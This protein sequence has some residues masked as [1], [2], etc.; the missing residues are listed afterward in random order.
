MIF[1]QFCT[2][3]GDISYLLAD[4]VTR[5]AALLDPHV[6][7]RTD[8][9]AVIRRLDLRLVYLIETHLHESHL[10]AAPALRADTDAQ[11]VAHNCV[12]LVCVDR[13][14]VD[15]ESIFMGEE[16]INAMETPGHSA[17]SMSYLWRDRVF[18]GHTLLAG[19]TGPCHRDDADADRL[20]DSVRDRLFV[21]PKET[22]V[23]PGRATG[24]RRGSTI[25]DECA[26]NVDLRPRMT[27]AEFV[28]VKRL[29]LARGR[30]WQTD[31]LEDN[32]GCGVF[33]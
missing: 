3:D 14:V 24:H 18:T 4:P 16:R 27:R 33:A 15:D 13:R 19:A 25:G 30:V 6:D 28:A 20:F 2:D 32:R 12:D 29:E 17:C 21:L 7:A 5:Y 26:G 22:L 8:Y 31:S 1:R 11:V 9:G 10:S 23:C